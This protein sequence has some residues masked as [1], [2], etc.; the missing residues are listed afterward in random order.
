MSPSSPTIAHAYRG[1]FAPSPTGPLHAGSLVAAV[2]SFL[3]A[4]AA[5]GQWH[6]RIDDIDPPREVV[7]AA[8]NIIKCLQLHGLVGDTPTI[9]QHQNIKA[10]RQAI[11]ILMGSAAVFACR[12]TRHRLGPQGIC[13]DGCE[14]M[15]IRNEATSLR[16]KVPANTLIVFD[17]LVCGPQSFPLGKT[18]PNFIIRRRDSLIAYQLAAAIDDGSDGISH[19]IR[20]ADLAS[21]TPRQ[22]Y[23]QQLLKL[24]TPQYGHLPLVMG[25]DG[26]KLSKQTGA[27]ALDV[28]D[29]GANLRAALAVL[30]QPSPAPSLNEPKAILAS[31]G[32]HWDRKCIPK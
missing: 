11:D 14:R 31:A 13:I 2:A 6:I 23:L 15:T 3:D 10:H 32:N 19:V 29:A 27:A 24:A 5:K 21:S 22:I 12:C 9:F 17:D 25:A 26:H 1:R 30:G 18:L 8:Q 28:S 7:G 20:G 4:Y 16:I